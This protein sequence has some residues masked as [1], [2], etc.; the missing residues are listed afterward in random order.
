MRGIDADQYES[1]QSRNLSW[2]PFI[3]AE[4]DLSELERSEVGVDDDQA[5]S[6]QSY[7]PRKLCI[8]VEGDQ[9]KVSHGLVTRAL[10]HYRPEPS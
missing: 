10:I 9:G 8:K 6:E 7:Q 3:K 4:G 2:S 5:Q 1:D